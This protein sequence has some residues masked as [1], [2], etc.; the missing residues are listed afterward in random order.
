MLFDFPARILYRHHRD[1][2]EPMHV[3]SCNYRC[4]VKIGVVLAL[5][6][7]ARVALTSPRILVDLGILANSTLSH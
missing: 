2:Y 5:A 4:L 7:T 3:V 6:Y 1:L